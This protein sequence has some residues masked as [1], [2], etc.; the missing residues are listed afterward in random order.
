MTKHAMSRATLR[1]TATMR[2]AKRRI[3]DHRT[4]IDM[5]SFGSTHPVFTIAMRSWTW[6][7]TIA[8]ACFARATAV[9]V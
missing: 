2:S 3:C 8:P 5:V 4:K 9:K 1:E 6:K 7:V